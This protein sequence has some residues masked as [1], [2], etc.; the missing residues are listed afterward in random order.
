MLVF[1]SIT[2]T[3]PEVAVARPEF[4]TYTYLPLGVTAIPVGTLPTGMVAIIE[5]VHVSMTVAK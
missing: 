4:A 2:D 3:E 5:L 1:V